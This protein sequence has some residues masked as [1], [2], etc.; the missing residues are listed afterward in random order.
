MAPRP[1]E[2]APRLAPGRP[3]REAE[4]PFH[5]HP[6]PTP[7]R[8]GRGPFE[9]DRPALE[10]DAPGWPFSFQIPLAKRKQKFDC[11]YSWHRVSPEERT[12]PHAFEDVTPASRSVISIVLVEA[13]NGVV[14]GLRLVSFSPEFSR[15]INRAI[16]DQAAAEF[17][18][19][20]HDQWAAEML[21][22]T[23][24]QLWERCTVRC[25]GGAD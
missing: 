12:A 21:R 7:G 19:A 5:R 6:S 22:Y 13:T 10:H 15:A 17:D 4:P 2:D 8:F 20:G 3:A 18:P 23:T 16:A 1:A 11:S 9:L 24:Q 25:E 14:L